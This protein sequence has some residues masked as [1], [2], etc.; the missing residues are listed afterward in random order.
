[1]RAVHL[2]VDTGNDR[3]RRLYERSGFAVRERYHLMTK[4]L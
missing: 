3:A 4:V 1:V 2:E